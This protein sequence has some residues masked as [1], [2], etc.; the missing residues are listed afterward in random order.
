M[1]VLI[2]HS[3]YGGLLFLLR[4][5]ENSFSRIRTQMHPF[6]LLQLETNVSFQSPPLCSLLSRVSQCK[7]P[8]IFCYHRL[9]LSLNRA[10]DGTL[11]ADWQEPSTVRSNLQSD[12]YALFIPNNGTHSS[13]GQ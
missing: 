6:P 13:L 2:V 11:E 10:E 7:V 9:P 5:V 8:C 1:T 4:S 3:E 12:I